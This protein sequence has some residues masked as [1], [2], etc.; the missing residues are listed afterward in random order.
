LTLAACSSEK[1]EEPEVVA[2]NTETSQDTVVGDGS[3]PP[4]GYPKSRS[5]SPMTQVTLDT[6]RKMKKKFGITRDQYW[7]EKGGV[8]GNEFFEVWYPAGRVTVTHGMQAFVHLMPAHEK[9][10]QF[11]DDS[12]S[13]RLVI[14]TWDYLEYYKRD[15]GRDFWYYSVIEGDSMKM[16]PVSVFYARGIDGVAIPHEYYQWAIGKITHNG[17][18]RWIEEG[19]ASYLSGE[20]EILT[21]QM[22][23]FPDRK[24][25]M[26][27]AEIEKILIREENKADSRTA[28]YHSYMMVTKLVEEFGET[29][30]RKAILEIARGKNIEDAV[31]SVYNKKYADLLE[32]ATGYNAD[33]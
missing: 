17:A 25:P 4:P 6:L 19:V 13:D 14:K 31:E 33:L 16:Q 32:I 2:Q 26:N 15:V 11:F 21:G 1:K 23:E 3:G 9:F 20:G 18:P 30:L 28:Y 5:L 27:P 10:N 8:L 24:A 7:K 12:P 29:N 22:V